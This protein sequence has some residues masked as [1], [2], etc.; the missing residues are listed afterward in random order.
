MFRAGTRDS[1]GRFMGGT[2]LFTL[3]SHAGKLWASIGYYWDEPGGDPSPGAQVL[4]LDRPGL[5]RVLSLPPDADQQVEQPPGTLHRPALALDV[6]VRERE[7]AL[8]AHPVRVLV[9]DE[10]RAAPDVLGLLGVRVA[11]L[12]EVA[13]R[14]PGHLQVRELLEGRREAIALDRW[15]RRKDGAKIWTQ[16]NVVLIRDE[17]GRPHRTYAIVQDETARRTAEAELLQR[18][19]EKLAEGR[20]VAERS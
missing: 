12:P 2:E 6:V 4:V 13:E 19:R 9:I 20:R 15:Y 1:A 10:E 16:V 11:D 17:Q 7:H 14:R 5:V 3:V 8:Q 18:G